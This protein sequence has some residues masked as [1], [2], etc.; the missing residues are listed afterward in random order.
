MVEITLKNRI[1]YCNSTFQMTFH[2]SNHI[3]YE[4]VLFEAII[5]QR[6]TENNPCVNLINFYSRG[7]HCA[8]YKAQRGKDHQCDKQEQ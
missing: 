3:T 6:L 1:V 5:Q 8:V 7:L 2:L 4:T